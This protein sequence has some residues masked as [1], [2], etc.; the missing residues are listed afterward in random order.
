MN[1]YY[2]NSGNYNNTIDNMLMPDESV[3][4]RGT[5]KKSAFILNSSTKMMP[6]ALIW[7]AFDGFF[8]FSVVATGAAS[9][10]G[11][12]GLFLVFFFAIHLMPVW[13]WLGNM[14]TSVGRWKNTEYAVT[15]K[16]IIIRNGLFGY[17]YQSIYYTDVSNVSLRVGVIDRMLGVGDVH[18]YTNTYVGKRSAGPAILDVPDVQ[19]VFSMLQSTVMNVQSDIQ[20][21][22]TYRSNTNSGSTTTYQ[23]NDRADF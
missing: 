1:K 7:L 10:M 14:I 3:I 19:Y 16:R 6:I 9:D 12:M 17:E 21:N 4:W 5:P 22:N 18:I 13:I 23:S 2:T 15:D 20:Y 8:I 11:P